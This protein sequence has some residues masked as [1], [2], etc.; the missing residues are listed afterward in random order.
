MK[1]REFIKCPFILPLLPDLDSLNAKI[2]RGISS[3]KR[4]NH[5][6][7]LSLEDGFWFRTDNNVKEDTTHIS[8]GNPHNIDKRFTKEKL[9]DFMYRSAKIN[10]SNYVFHV[11]DRFN[12]IRSLFSCEKTIPS[13][14]YHFTYYPWDESPNTKSIRIITDLTLEDNI[15]H[16]TDS[17]QIADLSDVFTNVLYIGEYEFVRD[18]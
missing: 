3:L 15:I 2:E 7:I 6:K 8:L 11:Y 10:Y 5:V 18:F 12:R 14:S 17:F 13:S 16:S 9:Q 4:F 1:R